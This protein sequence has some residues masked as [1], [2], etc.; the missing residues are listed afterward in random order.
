MSAGVQANYVAVTVFFAE[1]TRPP[2][3]PHRAL[4]DPDSHRVGHHTINTQN[5]IHAVSADQAA[6]NDRIDLIESDKTRGFSGVNRLRLSA[7]NR[8]SHGR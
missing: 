2:I 5:H 6:G 1:V 4:F 7:P 8:H 3:E